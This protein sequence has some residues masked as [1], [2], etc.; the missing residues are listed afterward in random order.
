MEPNATI[1]MNKMGGLHIWAG[2]VDPVKV[3]KYMFKDEEGND[4]DIYIQGNDGVDSILDNL[5][6]DDRDDVR[7]G[8]SVYCWIPEELVCV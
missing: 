6:E 8:W 5:S 7:S 3:G 2:K 4:A 1:Q